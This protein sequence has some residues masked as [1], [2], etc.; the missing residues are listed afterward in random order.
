MSW[1]A[2]AAPSRN[3]I[4]SWISK[5]RV[6]RPSFTPRPYSMGTSM[7]NRSSCPALRASSSSDNGAA[8]NPESVRSTLASGAASPRPRNAAA[9]SSSNERVTAR[10]SAVLLC[11]RKDGARIPQ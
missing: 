1:N 7:R 2:P 10:A 3:V 5:S 11:A 4:A 8:R 9:A 6:T